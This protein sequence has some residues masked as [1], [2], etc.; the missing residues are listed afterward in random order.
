MS[1]I[2]CEPRAPLLP[3]EG[4][5]A[6]A[7]LVLCGSVCAPRR[8]SAPSGPLTASSDATPRERG[9]VIWL[10]LDIDGDA[11]ATALPPHCNSPLG[12]RCSMTVRNTI[13]ERLGVR[14]CASRQTRPTSSRLRPTFELWAEARALARRGPGVSSHAARRVFTL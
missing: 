11:V 9:A 4:G 13:L 12:T 8:S 3:L 7:L 5:C 2:S 6:R 1:G 10:V 14:R